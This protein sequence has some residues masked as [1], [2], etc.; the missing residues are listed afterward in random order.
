MKM[1]ELQNLKT[2]NNKKDG[3]AVFFYLLN[4]ESNIIME[5]KNI[6]LN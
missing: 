1:K 3:N 4:L 2:L 6:I 5:K